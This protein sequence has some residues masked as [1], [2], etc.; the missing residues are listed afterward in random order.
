VLV[1]DDNATNRHILE[2]WLRGWQM[3]PVAVA[4]A[5]VALDTLRHGAACGRPY[6]LVLLDARM[7]DVDGLALA[8]QIRGRAELAATRIIVLTSGDRPGD[9]ARLRELRVDAHLLK[10]VQQ[11]ELVETICAVMGRGEGATPPA[12]RP[13]GGRQ[14][15]PVP[16]PEAT[17][18]RVLVAED[19][20]FNAQLLEQLLV[21]RGHRVRLAG[22]GREALA[23][24]AE[25]GF[26]L[27]LLDVHMPELDGFQVA[28][29]VRERERAAGGRLPIIALTARSRQEDRERCLAAGMDDF[30]AKPVQAADLWAAMDR[31]VV[32]GAPAG[33]GLLDPRVLLATCGGDAAILE[34]LCQTFRARLPDHLE[35]VRDA[36]EGR[37]APRLREAAHKLCG[38]LAAFS[39]AAGGVASELEDLAE[40]GRLEEARTL[41]GQLQT[42]AEEL[43]RLV[44][45]LS[46]DAL[47]SHAGTSA[48]QRPVKRLP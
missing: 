39:T 4:G 45:G 34:K 24:A 44:R 3:W 40:Q 28:R 30:L 10:P 46:P 41:V 31:V 15:A 47:R 23:L 12:A 9:L 25:G 35:A 16:A 1:V 43:L 42:M 17:P 33:P 26:D 32:V 29:A 21:R 14:Q 48:D 13:A 20:E 2:E 7:P 22:N 5:A 8:A 19:N 27:L 18:L 11:D 6:P 37:D 36:L 38:T